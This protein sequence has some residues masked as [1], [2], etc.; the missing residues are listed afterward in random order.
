MYNQVVRGIHASKVARTRSISARYGR[1]R[2]SSAEGNSIQGKSTHWHP[3]RRCAASAVRP[4]VGYGYGHAAAAGTPVAVA[5]AVPA[6]C[7][8]VDGRRA[9]KL[10]NHHRPHPRCS[11][12]SVF[13]PSR[14]HPTARRIA[15]RWRVTQSWRFTKQLDVAI[16]TPFER[17]SPLP[18][19]RPS[20]TH[21][22]PTAARPSSVR[23]QGG[24]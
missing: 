18:T 5:V 14:T 9:P 21:L 12:R 16:W 24:T 4:S 17:P 13:F 22:T 6:V 20:P 19:A 15:Q 11:I 8:R 1:T 3:P 10:I 23:A 2:H 7:S